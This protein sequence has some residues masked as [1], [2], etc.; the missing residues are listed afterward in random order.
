MID[1]AVFL[2]I[3]LAIIKDKY[4]KN[5]SIQKNYREIIF[6]HLKNFAEIFFLLLKA[7]QILAH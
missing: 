2:I 5:N 1:L 7:N 3:C 6:L 4:Q